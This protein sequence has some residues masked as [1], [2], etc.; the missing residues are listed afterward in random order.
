MGTKD[1]KA[2]VAVTKK[3]SIFPDVNLPGGIS[4]KATEYKDLAAKGDKWESPVFGIGSAKETSNLP[5]APKIIR[6]PHG[7]AQGYSSKS[8][9]VPGVGGQSNPAYGDNSAL[10]TANTSGFS[11]QVDQAFQGKTNG[12]VNGNTH[13]SLGT[14][15]PVYSGSA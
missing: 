13:T 4:T 5:S 3:D 14:S 15:N 12:A 2:N 1:T 9:A 10:G 6:K 7:T 11:N 8:A